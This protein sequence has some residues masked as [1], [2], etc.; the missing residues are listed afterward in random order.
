MKLILFCGMQCLCPVKHLP[1]KINSFAKRNFLAA[2]IFFISL[3]FISPVKSQVYP[4]GFNQVLVAGGITNPTVMAFAPDG[5]IFVAQQNGQLR[6]IKNGALLVQPFI[7]LSVSSSGERG[8]LGIAF[9]PAFAT[10]NFIYLYYTLSSALN[11]RISRFTANGDVAVAGSEVVILDL[12]PLSSATNHNGGTLHFGADGFLYL[13]TGDG[14]GGGDVPGNAQ[15]TAVLLGKIL[16]LNVNTSLTA[17]YYTVPADN[18]FGNEVYA[19][20]LRNPF[21]WSFDRLTNDMW[22]GDVGQDSFEEINHRLAGDIKGSNFGWRCYEGNNS[23]NTSGCGP[24]SNYTFPIF[25]YPDPVGNVSVAVTGGTVYRGETYIGLRGYYLAS[26]YYSAV[27][28]KIK[29][30]PVT[31]IYD[32]SSQVITP[33]G[34]SNFG[35]TEDGELYV[36]CLNNGTLYRVVSNGAIQYTFTGNGNWDVANN[37]SNKTIPPATLPAGSEIVIRPSVSGEC[38]LN[39]L[40]TISPGSKITVQNDKQFRIAGNLTIQ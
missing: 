12:D 39:T 29:Y 22:I 32:T 20:G 1:V 18:P 3:A 17:P 36:T 14:G 26:D 6:I 27:F 24:I 11:N 33:A 15:N 7:S 28:Y 2:F 25:T 23:F 5:R 19:Y 35:E 13:S 8:L 21:R 37:W 10:N 40:Q 4:G 31:H 9:D 38:V 30:D 16:R 34:I